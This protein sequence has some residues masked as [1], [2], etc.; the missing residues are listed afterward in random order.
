[1]QYREENNFPRA[2][3]FS[4]LAMILFLGI[5]YWITFGSGIDVELKESGIGGIVV[6]YGTSETGMGDDIHGI[7][8]PSVAE[9]A[10]NSQKNIISETP[11][12]TAPSN[13]ATNNAIVT[14]NTDD[15][16]TVSTSEKS[17]NSTPATA[18]PS[19]PAA[20]PSVDA[21]AIY[22]GKKNNGTGAGDGTGNTP[23][24]QGERGGDPLASNYG[25]GGSG[26]GGTQLTIAGRSFVSPPRISDDG[27]TSG[28]I[29]VEI[30]VDQT[31]RVIYARAGVKG[32]TISDKGLWAKCEAAA[33]SSSLNRL[34]SAPDTQTGTVI[35]NFKVQ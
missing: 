24:N 6:N 2:F 33:L 19:K 35:F 3:L 4:G 29:A 18:T 25:K 30:R 20:K 5:S 14:Q 26:F 27:Q 31:G 1:M 28:K 32:T 15:A 12:E 10:D 16:P 34:E 21:R 17:N 13:E 7:E 23:G 9:N 22:T 8:E 11:S